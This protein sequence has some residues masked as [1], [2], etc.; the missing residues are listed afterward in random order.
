M[1]SP[2]AV[3]IPWYNFCLLLVSSINPK[4]G[5]I[6]PAV[7]SDILTFPAREP[8]ILNHDILNCTHESVQGNH[9]YSGRA[10]GMS[11]PDDVIQLHP[12]LRP[13]W[14]AIAAHYQRIGLQHASNVIWDVSYD[15]LKRHSQRQVSVF[16][17]HDS[18][19]VS[20]PDA[21]WTRTVDYVNDKNNFMD[22]AGELGMAVPMTLRF[23]DRL[24]VRDLDTLPYP[25]YVKASVSVAG[26]GSCRCET[27]S[28]VREALATF[29]PNV[30]LQIQEEVVTDRFLNI[31]YE[32]VNQTLHR[33]MIT[34][35]VLDGFAHQ[36]NR[37][38]SKHAP[39]NSVEIMAHWMATSGMKGRFSFDVAVVKTASGYQY[40]P[41]ACSPRF[42]GAS[43][44][45]AVAMK[46]ALD[47]WTSVQLPTRHRHLVHLDLNGIEYDP[48][49]GS[50]VVIINWGPVLAGKVGFLLAGSAERQKALRLEL[51]R[52]L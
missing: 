40:L 32:I 47:A 8:R 15:H 3:D 7:V 5:N 19:E 35:Q 16:F 14:P 9:L 42:N 49:T 43:Y 22:L 41:I 25:C 45:A 11:E 52:R 21:N 2:E 30:P 50:G 48:G 6:L 33:L 34:E 38:P 23:S 44:P 39:W 17:F 12:E 37:Y 31:Q 26:V 4:R 46:L 10:L 20:R 28:E 13:E 36:S 24:Q 27:A 29:A 18:I 51:M 1:Q